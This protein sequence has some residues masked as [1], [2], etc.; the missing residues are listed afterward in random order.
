MNIAEQTSARTCQ[1]RGSGAASVIVPPRAGS[2][3]DNE[4]AA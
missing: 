2:E 1:R 4:C 3:R